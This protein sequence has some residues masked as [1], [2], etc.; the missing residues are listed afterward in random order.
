MFD[1]NAQWSQVEEVSFKDG[2]RLVNQNRSD[3]GLPN[4]IA[5]HANVRKFWLDHSATITQ[6]WAAMTPQ[7]RYNF[8]RTCEPTLPESAKNPTALI[9]GRREDVHGAAVLLPELCVDRLTSN[10]HLA[11][12]Y[13]DV[14]ESAHFR[15]YAIRSLDFVAAGLAQNV[16]FPRERHNPRKFYITSSESFGQCYEFTRKLTKE[17]VE[18]QKMF[19]SWGAMVSND[20][21]EMMMT[22]T[23]YLLNA[24]ANFAEE[25]RVTVLQKKEGQRKIISAAVG[26]QACGAAKKKDDGGALQSC[27]RCM[28][29]FYCSRDC[30]VKDWPNH[31]LTC[32]KI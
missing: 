27:S 31:K 22:R 32:K 10:N 14:A 5:L 11:A 1:P 24:L 13:S 3:Q 16:L 26:C 4:I 25:F 15:D 7:T 17:D 6:T 19:R 21:F 30:Q 8:I 2:S 23:S 29:A 12:L 9:D 20:E 28:I 18:K